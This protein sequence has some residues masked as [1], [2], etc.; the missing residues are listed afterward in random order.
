VTDGLIA[1]EAMVALIGLPNSTQDMRVFVPVAP[2]KPPGI[3][4]VPNVMGCEFVVD[5]LKSQF[6][7]NIYD[8]C[9]I[10]I[11]Q[12]RNTTFNCG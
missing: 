6:S 2:T 10:S 4:M 8:G 1:E 9:G 7:E 5:P 11:D 12:G 3:Q